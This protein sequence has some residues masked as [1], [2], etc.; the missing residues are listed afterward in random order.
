MSKTTVDAIVA[1]ITLALILGIALGLWMVL[2]S[3]GK[4]SSMDFELRLLATGKEE[5]RLDYFSLRCGV[6]AT[7]AHWYLSRKAR[8]LNGLREIDEFGDTFFLFGEAKRK[9][10]LEATK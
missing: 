8:Q 10:L 7:V 1:L 5:V 3:M 6:H 2:W 9:Y 4:L